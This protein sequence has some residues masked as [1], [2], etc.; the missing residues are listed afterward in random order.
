MAETTTTPKLPDNVET[1]KTPD[2]KQKNTETD[3]VKYNKDVQLEGKV[4]VIEIKGGNDI[5]N[6]KEFVEERAKIEANR[7]GRPVKVKLKM[8]KKSKGGGGGPGNARDINTPEG[9]GKIAPGY[10]NSGLRTGQ[11]ENM[12]R[13]SAIMR[14]IDPNYAVAVARGE[15]LNTYRSSAPGDK[16]GLSKEPSYGPFQLLIGA[17]RA[18]GTSGIGGLG[19]RYIAA[20]YN[21]PSV[22][23][24]PQSIRNQIDFALNEAAR[25]GWGQWYGRPGGKYGS[26]TAGLGNAHPVPVGSGYGDN[27][28][29]SNQNYPSAP[30]QGSGTGSTP[31][32]GGGGSTS[33]G[34]DDEETYESKEAKPDGRDNDINKRAVKKD[35]GDTEEAKKL[36]K[37]P[38][39]G[40]RSKKGFNK[41]FEGTLGVKDDDNEGT[42]QGSTTGDSFQTEQLNDFKGG[43]PR[44][45]SGQI[46][47][48]ESILMSIPNQAIGQFVGQ[49]P[50]PLQGLIPPG[51]ISGI[52]GNSP[53]SLNG[54]MQLVGGGAL[55]Q[56]A[57]SLIRSTSG[58]INLAQNMSGLQGVSPSQIF[59]NSQI[60]NSN[61]AAIANTL[62]SVTRVATNRSASGIPVDLTTLTRSIQLVLRQSG[63]GVPI[64]TNILG[65]AGQVAAQ[66]IGAIINQ[67]LGGLLGGLN[68]PILPSNLSLPN[69]ALI[70]GLSQFLPPGVAQNI[71]TVGQLTG[72]LPGNLQNQIPTVSP[73]VSNGGVPNAIE[74]N[75]NASPELAPGTSSDKNMPNQS[76][77]SGGGGKYNGKEEE[78]TK[79]STGG[80]R[81]INYDMKI[82]KYL[83]LAQVTTHALVKGHKLVPHMGLS[84]DEI[85]ENLSAVA[86]NCYDPLHEKWGPAHV[87]SGF[88]EN[89]QTDHGR[90]C[91]L[92]LSFGGNHARLYEIA[93]WCTEGNIPFRQIILERQKSSWLHV[94][95]KKGEKAAYPV[96]TQIPGTSGAG[97]RYNHSL[98]N[99]Y[100][101]R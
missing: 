94:A 87:N 8:P 59:A 56:A 95:Y 38:E 3:E 28:T 82:S 1:G 48:M 24:S 17:Q 53:V 34:N 33:G 29:S 18:P 47:P 55:G 4:T 92:D 67:A 98:I 14:G 21:D 70:S 60:P 101:N 42:S 69:S 76:G 49:L 46:P 63:M 91:A 51:L 35:E 86:K 54:L 88:R 97:S 30:Q 15:G 58:G 2:T 27:Q 16:W 93:K 25:K 43:I 99:Y 77:G 52:G 79:G 100:G 75:R 89:S 83:T 37:P 7:L 45:F 72:L 78:G 20:G 9:G 80:G 11:V 65:I 64:P 23:R 81:Y 39:M 32:S 10:E 61:P 90:G 73:S 74:Q 50:G 6:P 31:N 26:K 62:G 40:T 66:A 85:I 36:R 71:F 5:K 84:V 12:I 19:D 44:E 68:V 96:M 57:G 41:P 13:Q 22:D